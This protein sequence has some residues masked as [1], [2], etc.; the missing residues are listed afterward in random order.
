M[1][2]TGPSS[3]QLPSKT[4]P[5]PRW[6]YVPQSHKGLLTEIPQ[7]NLR[8]T[9]IS[10]PTRPVSAA[11]LAISRLLEGTLPR[12]KSCAQRETHRGGLG[13]LESDQESTFYRWTNGGLGT[14]RKW[15][16]RKWQGRK[17]PQ[18]L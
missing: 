13:N 3:G 1:T 14:G 7:A 16:G 15:Q 2:T 18:V 10:G 11:A 4:P 5:P 6:P 9:S 17:W 12:F 8:T